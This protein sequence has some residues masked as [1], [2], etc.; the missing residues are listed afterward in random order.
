MKLGKI[1]VVGIGLMAAVVVGCQGQGSG[2]VEG[3]VDPMTGQATLESGRVEAGSYVWGTQKAVS[4]AR[5]IEVGDHPNILL[6]AFEIGNRTQRVRY[7]LADDA[8]TTA[9]LKDS[10]A[11]QLL[12]KDA[13][14]SKSENPKWSLFG[15]VIHAPALLGI[16]KF[17]SNS[18]YNGW[19]VAPQINLCATKML[20][21]LKAAGDQKSKVFQNWQIEKVNIFVKPVQHAKDAESRMAIDA[22]LRALNVQ[23]SLWTRSGDCFTPG[24]PELAEALAIADQHIED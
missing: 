21:N 5:Q 7:F 16:A 8:Q 10:A 11:D 24:V 14:I 15:Y 4:P 13:N 17:S 19:A 1:L 12:G 3:G 6:E 9:L 18:M 2:G 22:K 23:V 20:D